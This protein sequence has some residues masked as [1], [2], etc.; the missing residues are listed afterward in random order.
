MYLT[1]IPGNALVGLDS[2]E[3]LSFYDNKLVKVPQLALQKV[4][5]LKFLDLNKNPIHK[6]QEGDF[7]NMLRLKELGINN[8]G[9]LVSVD[10]YALDNLPE[11]TKLEATNNPKLSYIHRLAL[12][13]S[14]PRELD[15]EQQRSWML[16]IKRQ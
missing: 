16:F 12:K 4:P 7:K 10:R 2:L 1:D 11:L 5:N 9:E 15:V 3:S 6:I 13:C 8:M 14:C